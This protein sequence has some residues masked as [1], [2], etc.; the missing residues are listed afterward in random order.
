MSLLSVIEQNQIK[1]GIPPFKPGDTV[2]VHVKIQEGDKFRIQVFEGLVIAMRRNGASSTF[3][4]RK[5][6]FG[7]GVERI[8]PWYSPVIDKI[9]ILKSGKVRRAKLYYLRGRKGKAARLK[10]V[11]ATAAV[12]VEAKVE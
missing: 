12:A 6:S 8:F 9:E 11:R 4:V 3:T 7:Y 1:A 2:R 5:I 10:E